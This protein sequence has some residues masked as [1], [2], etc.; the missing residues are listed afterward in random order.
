MIPNLHAIDEFALPWEPFRDGIEAS[1]LYRNG[2]DGPA[3]AFLRY[4]PGARVPLHRHRGYEHVYIL[5]GSQTD[6]NGRL[7]AGSFIVNPPDTQHDV[8]SEDGCL[9]LLVWQ[10]P[11]EIIGE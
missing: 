8:I 10:I 7:G 3:A 1:W 6:R 2:P 5:R 11:V 9:A 4:L